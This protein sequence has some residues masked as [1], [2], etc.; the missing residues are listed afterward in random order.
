MP[1]LPNFE[2]KKKS[3]VAILATQIWLIPLA[4]DQESNYFT[5]LKRKK[6]KKSHSSHDL[7]IA[8]QNVVVE[9]I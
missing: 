9:V 8:T 6:K 7:N 1:K 4:D 3:E 5:K 2:G